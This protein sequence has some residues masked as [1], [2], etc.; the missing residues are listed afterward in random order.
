MSGNGPVFCFLGAAAF[1]GDF[2]PVGDLALPPPPP[3]CAPFASDFLSP[4]PPSLALKF[5]RIF[6]TNIDT[7]FKRRN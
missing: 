2:L 5:Q 3:A 4:P 1:A 7:N 6:Y